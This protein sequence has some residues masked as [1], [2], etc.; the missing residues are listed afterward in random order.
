[1]RLIINHLMCLGSLEPFMI[2][3]LRQIISF[4]Q[5]YSVLKYLLRTKL[6]HNLQ[7][8]CNI[9]MGRQRRAGLS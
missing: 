7:C 3:P 2:I 4:A 1:M 6:L 5:R 8:Q 9:A